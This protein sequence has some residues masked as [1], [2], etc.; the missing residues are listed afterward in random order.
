M[1]MK[2]LLLQGLLGLA[3]VLWSSATSAEV[4]VI[5][6]A[7]SQIVSLNTNQVANIFLG[8][9]SRYP[10]GS[11]AIPIDQP[12]DSPVR[13]EFY[14]KTARMS[15]SMVKEHWSRLVFTGRGQPPREAESSDAVKKMVA[16][17][18]KFLGYIDRSVVDAS[19]RVVL[20]PE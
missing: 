6:S 2:Y 12:E 1:H 9:S 4:V 3:F 11:E 18:P 15:P 17:N 14:T 5:V 10:S 20:V 8:R 7:K 16:E 13:Q 19:V